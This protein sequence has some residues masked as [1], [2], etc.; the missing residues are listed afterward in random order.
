[1]KMKLIK[2]REQPP[3]AGLPASYREWWDL[4]NGCEVF[5]FLDKKNCRLLINDY[6]SKDI[7]LQLASYLGVDISPEKMIKFGGQSDGRELY[8]SLGIDCI[9]LNY[10]KPE[11]YKGLLKKIEVIVNE[12]FK[13]K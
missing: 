2:T 11:D 13:P 1:M 5:L 12:R 4:G 8:L 9:A 6:K 7:T 10:T 3:Q